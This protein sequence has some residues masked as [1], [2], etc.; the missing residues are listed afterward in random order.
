M[1]LWAEFENEQP[2]QAPGTVPTESAGRAR[3]Q[4][5]WQGRRLTEQGFLSS[6][7]DWLLRDYVASYCRSLATT[8][9]YRRC[10]WIDGLG[11]AMLQPVMALSEEL[12][13]E[14]RP[15]ELRGILL[16]A[17]SSKRKEGKAEEDEH[18]GRHSEISLPK[19]SGLVRASWLEIALR[20]LE[21]IDQSPAIFLLNPFGQML[22]TYDDL[23]PLYTRTAP[24][25]LCLLVSHKQVEKVVGTSQV[26]PP[27]TA[28]LRSDRWKGLV[29]SGDGVEQIVD[30]IID[31]LIASMQK[32]FLAVSRIALPVQMGPAMI[33]RA[34][35][36]L[37]FATRRLDSLVRMNDA[38]C[39]HRRRLYEQSLRG[40]LTEDWFVRQQRER[41][42]E[43]MQQL[44]TRAL[45]QGRSQGSQG[46]RRW[47]DLRQ[48]LMLAHFGQFT[49]DDYDEVMR[50]LLLNGEVRCEWRQRPAPAESAEDR[51]PGNEDTLI[52]K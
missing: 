14:H 23:A 46:V 37:I 40:V 16:E 8:R 30:G 12:A 49:L 13:K 44:Y 27:L 19:E 9:I 17:G 47:P 32:H 5:L 11:A 48:Q 6:L 34:P 43:E 35:Y 7:R 42:E 22:F 1:N 2:G 21:F 41:L 39:L 36:T 26:V 10:Y 38:V 4:R 24:T 18:G 15:I 29:S 3:K 50:K 25:E 20:L 45:Q 31:L 28:L 51:I 33:E 52:W